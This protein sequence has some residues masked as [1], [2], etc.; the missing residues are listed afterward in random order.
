MS[1]LV[2]RLIDDFSNK[3]YAHSYIEDHC[4]AAIAA[5]IK[6][7]REQ[8]GLTQKQLAELAGMK[9]ERISALENIDYDAWTTKTLH[10][11][12]KAFDVSLQVKFAP[13]SESVL[14]IANISRERLQVKS[15]A[16]DLNFYCAHRV[17]HTGAEWRL[18]DTQHLRVIKTYSVEPLSAGPVEP[19]ADWQTL[20][21]CKTA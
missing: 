20:D 15:R 18:V 14:D 11:L 13:F 7:I 5:Q 16:D 10:K 1:E 17:V 6:T 19:H 8:R 3:D 12:A 9:Q 21:Q 4:N 2:K